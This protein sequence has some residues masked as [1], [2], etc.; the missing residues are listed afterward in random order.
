MDQGMDINEAYTTSNVIVRTPINARSF[1]ALNHQNFIFFFLL[2]GIPIFYF[3]L[4]DQ[5]KKIVTHG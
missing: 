4:K 5:P 2:S 1:Y 3:I